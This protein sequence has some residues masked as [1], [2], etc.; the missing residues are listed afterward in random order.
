MKQSTLVYLHRPD[1]G[2]ILLAFKK[3]GFGMG[4]WNGVGGKVADGE[5]ILQTAVREVAEEIGVRLQEPSLEQVAEL[6]FYNQHPD[7]HFTGFVFMAT[8]WEGEPTESD[9]MQPAWFAY[10]GIPYEDMWE[11]DRLWLPRLLNGERVRAAFHFH[12]E[13]GVLHKHTIEPVSE[14]PRE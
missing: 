6:T 1:A 4:K 12:P 7:D 5:S 2:E 10:H 3:R 8:A 13:T 14:F 11:D 9:E